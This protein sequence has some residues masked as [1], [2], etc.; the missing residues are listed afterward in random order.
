MTTDDGGWTVEGVEISKEASCPLF[1]YDTEWGR[2]LHFDMECSGLKRAKRKIRTH[3]CPCW[4]A[5]A[6]W[7]TPGPE[8]KVGRYI[9][10]GTLFACCSGDCLS[11]P[12]KA[13]TVLSKK[14]IC[15]FCGWKYHRQS[16][17][18]EA[19]EVNEK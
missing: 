17:D 2:K 6:V 3:P 11:A 14:E 19:K 7:L 12:D 16:Q 5:A 13:W 9:T 15:K 18:D 8:H 4:A 1:F 10:G